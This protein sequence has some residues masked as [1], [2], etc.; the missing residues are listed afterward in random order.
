MS[1]VLRLSLH[2]GGFQEGG[3]RKLSNACLEPMTFG[4]F[5]NSKHS[6]RCQNNDDLKVRVSS[7]LLRKCYGGCY[8]EA[9]WLL[10]RLH[11]LDKCQLP[12]VPR[13]STWPL[14]ARRHARRHARRLELKHSCSNRCRETLLN[15]LHLF[16]TRTGFLVTTGV[17]KKVSTQSAGSIHVAFDRQ[18]WLQRSV[19]G[20][21][22][23][24]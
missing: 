24:P 10:W 13:S 15:H 20:Q 12:E 22:L 14:Y 21:A 18:L 6:S 5:K 3:N 4:K 17:E 19:L 2:N 8:C 11:T 7:T 16:V 23:C 9:K 1:F